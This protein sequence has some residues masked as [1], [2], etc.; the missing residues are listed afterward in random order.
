MNKRYTLILLKVAPGTGRKPG[1]GCSF[2]YESLKDWVSQS[3]SPGIRPPVG[4]MTF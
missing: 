2:E 3:A 1:A 4:L